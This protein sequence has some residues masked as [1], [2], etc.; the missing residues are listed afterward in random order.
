MRSTALG[1]SERV[2]DGL[3]AAHGPSNHGMQAPDAE[4]LGHYP[5]LGSDQVAEREPGEAPAGLGTAV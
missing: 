4:V 2:L 1:E 5:V 3:H